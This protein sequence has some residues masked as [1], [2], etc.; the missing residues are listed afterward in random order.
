M[1]SPFWGNKQWLRARSGL[2]AISVFAWGLYGLLEQFVWWFKFDLVRR[3]KPV[4]S[5]W[6]ICHQ[7]GREQPVAVFELYVFY[8]QWKSIQNWK[9]AGAGDQQYQR[10]GPTVQIANG[11]VWKPRRRQQRFYAVRRRQ[12]TGFCQQHDLFAAGHL[13]QRIGQ[14]WQ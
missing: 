12:V 4:W 6:Q 9:G 13:G 14:L 3:H 7:S 11:A 1:P 5:D 2:W 10:A 8:P